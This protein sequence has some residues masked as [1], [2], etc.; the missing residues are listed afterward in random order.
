M[1]ISCLMNGCSLDGRGSQISRRFAWKTLAHR[2]GCVFL[3]L[4]LGGAAAS[5]LAG[6]MSPKSGAQCDDGFDEVKNFA[7]SRDVRIP[8]S[9]NPLCT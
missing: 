6:Q 3:T 9:S 7:T 1:E 8:T 5:A 4:S 2:L